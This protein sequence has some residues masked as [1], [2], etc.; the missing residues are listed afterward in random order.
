M[1][2]EIETRFQAAKHTLATIV[3]STWRGHVAR[4]RY[5]QLRAAA[6]VLQR[7]YRRRVRCRQLRKLK[8][9]RTVVQ[10]IVFVQK[11]VRRALAVRSYKRTTRAAQTINRYEKINHMTTPAWP[12]VMTFL[13]VLRRDFIK[14]VKDRRCTAYARKRFEK[15][16]E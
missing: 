9:Y 7:W 15:E 3:Q 2:F 13:H 12:L 11:N 5:V 8:E 14:I 1:W 16:N 10:R 6:I 4:R